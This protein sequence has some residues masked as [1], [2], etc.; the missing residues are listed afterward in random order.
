[1]LVLASLWSKSA[2]KSMNLRDKLGL[3]TLK[4]A[5]VASVITFNIVSCL[6]VYN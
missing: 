1:M 4:E 6:G 2:N 5:D 3:F